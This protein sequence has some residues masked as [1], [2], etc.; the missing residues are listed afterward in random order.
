LL[1]AQCVDVIT[2]SPVGGLTESIVETLIAGVKKSARP[3]HTIR[4]AVDEG[5]APATGDGET[6]V[7][8]RE[9]RELELH[10]NVLV[11]IG[12]GKG[13]HR[14]T[15]PEVGKRL[16]ELGILG[17]AEATLFRVFRIGVIA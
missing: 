5:I 10:D 4:D 9:I 14:H 17:T 6:G 7:R 15:C 11:S 8:T 16:G 13:K 1:T 12:G 2:S 3:T